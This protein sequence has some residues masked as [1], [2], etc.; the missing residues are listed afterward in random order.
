VRAAGASPTW[1]RA[2]P[3]A[4]VPSAG[5]LGRHHRLGRGRLPGLRRRGVPHHRTAGIVGGPLWW[6][7]AV[8]AAG[9]PALTAIGFA[10]GAWFPAGSSPRWSRWWCSS[11]WRS[12]RRRPQGTTRT[13]SLAA[14]RGA[15]TSARFRGGP[16]STGI[17]PPVHRPGDVSRSLTVA[18]LGALGLPVARRRVARR[19]DHRGRPGRRRN[20]GDA[21]RH[22]RLDPHGM[23]VIPA[24]HDAASGQPV[25][26]RRAAARP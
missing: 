2:R 8:S 15:S 9:V 4:L 23:I 21:G 14:D 13:G 1:S 12:A 11:G 7:A 24:L 26:Y 16:R 25:S 3:A 19:R 6:P 5:H 10:A 20:R 17:C 18:L 22:R